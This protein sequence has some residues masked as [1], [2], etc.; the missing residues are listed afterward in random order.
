MGNPQGLHVYYPTEELAETQGELETTKTELDAVRSELRDATEEIKET[1]GELGTTKTNL[2]AVRSELR[3]LK[4]ILVAAGLVPKDQ[5]PR[6]NGESFGG[7]GG[8]QNG[9][10]ATADPEYGFEDY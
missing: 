3:E 10:N 7:F 2:D 8:T 4:A 5:S 6:M 1:K 9:S